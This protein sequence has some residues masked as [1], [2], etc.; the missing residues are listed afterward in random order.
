MAAVVDSVVVGV[1][2]ADQDRGHADVHVVQ[3]GPGHRLRR[4]DQRGGVA[5][6]AGGAGQRR[7]QRP[8]VQL[9]L[10][11]RGQQ[12]L[13]APVLRLGAA[14]HLR[15][16]PLAL[17][18]LPV[19]LGG[20]QD[21]MRPLPGQL[22]GRAQD[23]PERHA[24]P[25]R[26]GPPGRGRRGLHRR[27]LLAGLGQR[28]APQRVHVGVPPA[29]PVGRVRGPAEVHRDA[30]LLR[31]PDLGVVVLELVV[32][33]LVA[34]RRVRGPGLL[35]DVQVLAGPVVALVLGQVVAVAALLG[36]TAAGDDVHRDPPARELVQGGERAGGQGRGHEPRPVRDQEAQRL[37]VGGGVGGHL[38]AVGLG[39]GVAD[40]HPVEPG[41]L[42]G[43][44][45]PPDV[46]AVHDRAA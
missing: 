33:A 8:V 40:Q 4:A 46:A 10:G 36:V 31:G 37:G 1:V 6:R 18:R 14:Q 2:A 15:P 16:A 24:D 11:R 9:A 21:L 38:E 20:G 35:H 17:E 42:V 19:G 43:A 26:L 12:P 29:D 45:E 5:R 25:G 22:L 44:G 41:V 13:R 28:L 27:D 3:Q 30:R 32:A 34:E 39:R 7:P 23:G